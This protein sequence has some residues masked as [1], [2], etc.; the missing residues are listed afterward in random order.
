[1]GDFAHGKGNYYMNSQIPH[2]NRNKN[3]VLELSYCNL[4]E[5]EDPDQSM[6]FSFSQKK[7]ED[8]ETFRKQFDVKDILDKLVIKREFF[9]PQKAQDIQEFYIFEKVLS[10]FN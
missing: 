6:E 10:V 9:I 8:F 4:D 2:N 1:M 5:D 7:I 3:E